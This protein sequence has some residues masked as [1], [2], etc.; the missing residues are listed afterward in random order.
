M[1][2]G[3]E[4]PHETG[5]LALEIAKART[6]LGVQPRWTLETA[7]EKTMNWYLSLIHI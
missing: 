3:T 1:G 5:W 2:G 4:G 6:L 7:V